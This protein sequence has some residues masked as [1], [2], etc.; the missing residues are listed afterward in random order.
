MNKVM[1]VYTLIPPM[2]SIREI[3]QSQY[4]YDVPETWY[5]A[6][7]DVVSST[8]AIADGRYKE[9]CAV[10]VASVAAQL[11]IMQEN[12]APFVFGGDGASIL[13]PPEALDASRKALAGTRKLSREQFNLD[14]RVG[15]IPMR[16]ILSAGHQIRV[17]RLEM[18]A[19]FQQAI[20]NGGGMRYAEQ[21]LKDPSLNQ[22]YLV[23]EDVEPVADF[24][25][26]ECRWRAVPSANDENVSLILVATTSSTAEDNVIYQE[27]LAK[28]EAIYGNSLTRH[29]ISVKNLNLTF[30]PY[31]L[32]VDGRIRNQNAF[33]F[34]DALK[35][36]WTTFKGYIA[37]RFR[38]G[39]WGTYK[40]LFIEATDHEKFDDTLRMI[41]SGSEKQRLALIAYLDEQHQQGKLAYGTHISQASLVTC[42]VY[43]YFGHQ[44]HLID[45][46]DGGYT[47][48]SKAMKAQLQA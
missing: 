16:D 43:D 25:G 31:Q 7:T 24:Y 17:A 38:I 2:A 19:N 8:D 15:L 33:S 12:D 42:I 44:M 14:M 20:F 41:F 45:G 40:A 30:N 34:R 47:L 3:T 1:S 39:Q 6:I 35:L 5:V 36:M 26:V 13:I 22:A 46:E 48:A 28:I 23:A 29:P 21:L 32:S 10:A 27:V 18:S 4:Y 11:N 37:L 9:V